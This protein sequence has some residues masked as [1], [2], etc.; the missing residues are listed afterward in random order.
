MT[1]SVAPPATTWRVR[2]RKLGKVRFTSHRDTAT[3]VERAVR[4]MGL[5]VAMS[6]GFTSRPRISFGLGLPTGAESLAEYFDIDLVDRPDAPLPD[7]DALAA[8]FTDALPVG[9][10]VDA[11]VERAPGAASLQ[12]SVVACSWRIELA[13][14]DHRDAEAA[15]E[16]VLAA[17]AL[18]LARERKG[19][20]RT[21]DVRP[22]IEHL[23]VCPAMPDTRTT[24]DALLANWGRGLR[25]V[26][27]VE[28]LFPHLDPLDTA[29]R[30]L[31]TEQFIDSDGERRPVLALAVALLED[32][33]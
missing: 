26:E 25:P 17:T 20:R 15:V 7:L 14:V 32:P 1:A 9:Y 31:R 22:V 11:I 23:A 21:D 6:Q 12:E 16:R 4:R 5:Q 30:L 8:A 10:R 29:A 27:L 24:L 19:Q 3:H 13:G 2:Y 33:S 28:V 18:P